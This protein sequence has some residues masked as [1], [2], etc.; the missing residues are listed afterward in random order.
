M[1]L[2]VE[3]KDSKDS[4]TFS[5]LYTSFQLSADRSFWKLLTFFTETSL[6]G[7][8][9]GGTIGLAWQ[10]TKRKGKG[11]KFFVSCCALTEH[12]TPLIELLQFYADIE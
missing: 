9:L 10:T 5:Q 3:E 2:K 11:Q 4:C 7:I 8:N 1:V 6:T 12:K